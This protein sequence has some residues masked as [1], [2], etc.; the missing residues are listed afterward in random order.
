MRAAIMVP[1][2]LDQGSAEPAEERAAA[3]I[4]S[5][6]RPALAAGLAKA[7]EFSVQRVGEFM[8]KRIGTGD[9]NGS[10]NKWVAVE[11]EEGFP[12]GF[13]AKGASVRAS[14]F[15]E[16]QGTIERCSGRGVG[17][18]AG[19]KAMIGFFSDRAEYHTELGHAQ[20]TR[21]C[22]CRAPK[23]LD[24]A[25]GNWKG[26]IE[27]CGRS[28]FGLLRQNQIG[29][30]GRGIIHAPEDNVPEQP[31]DLEKTFISSDELMARRVLR[32]FSMIRHLA[33][34]ISLPPKT[35]FRALIPEPNHCSDTAERAP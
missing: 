30:L 27:I 28:L 24:E 26:L 7:V 17:N 1:P 5:E 14:Q 15:S 3:R 23:L 2:S 12:R 6:R 34:T 31:K 11:A 16:M 33:G 21:F 9:G 20:A 19:R 32:T 25:F 22:L 18:Q 13:A 29:G 8:A 4:G 35:N 10:V